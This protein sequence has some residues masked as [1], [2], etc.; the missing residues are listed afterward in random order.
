MIRYLKRVLLTV[1]SVIL[2]I[3]LSFIMCSCQKHDLMISFDM[4]T[5]DNLPMPAGRSFYVSGSI[6]SGM[7]VP[8]DA[9]FELDMLDQNGKVIRHVCDPKKDSGSYYVYPE[10]TEKFCTDMDQVN[11]VIK[12]TDQCEYLVTDTSDPDSSFRNA[13]IKCSFSGTGF[14]ALIVGGGR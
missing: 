3:S 14:K 1:A 11:K 2:L 7:D 4:P 13:E 6:D 9:V 10:M 8:S 5:E 12:T